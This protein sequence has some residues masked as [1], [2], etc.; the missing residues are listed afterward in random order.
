M[1]HL[2]EDELRIVARAPLFG[3]LGTSD[4]TALVTRATLVAPGR[5]QMLFSRGDPAD[6]IYLVLQGRVKLI[7]IDQSGTEAVV[8]TF[9]SGE[10]FA[11]GA[12][13]AG[14]RYP[15]SAST[16][17]PCRLLQFETRHLKAEIQ[18]RPEL[19]MA[20]LASMAHHLKVLVEQIADLK[21]LT[22]DQRLAWFLVQRL[23]TAEDGKTIRF[24]YGRAVLASE[25]G[26]KA[27]TF[28]RALRRLARFHVSV[29]GDTVTVAD[30]AGLARYVRVAS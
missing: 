18:N 2:S 20:M 7:R 19:A 23:R 9:G 16:L 17:E 22:A 29:A 24:A 14:G 1:A 13:F 6:M 8:R 25:L 15:V 4:L 12:A 3:T 10:T 5:G 28:S 21:L 27:E 26:M 30:P 11:E